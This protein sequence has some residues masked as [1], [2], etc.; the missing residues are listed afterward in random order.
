MGLK[1]LVGFRLVGRRDRRNV[2]GGMGR[3]VWDDRRRKQLEQSPGGGKIQR[4][5][6]VSDCLIGCSSRC[7]E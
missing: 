7:P 2:M 4:L 1:E 6:L 3:Y 5:T